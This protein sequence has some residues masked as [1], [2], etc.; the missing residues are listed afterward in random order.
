MTANT[1]GA[2]NTAAGVNALLANTTG[3]QN[4]AVGVN[5]IFNNKTGSNNIALGF[6]AGFNLTTG[7]N[8]VDIANVGAGAES[9]TIRIGTQGKQTAAFIAGV[10][11]TLVTGNAVVVSS[12]GKLGVVMS[13]ARFK[14]DIKDMGNSSEALMK[15]RPV[16]FKYKN[17]PEGIKQ[18]GLI[19]EEVARI[20]PELVGYGADGKVESVRYLTLTAMLLNELQ[21]Q[22]A[23]NKLQTEQIT[24]LS[25]K[26]SQV[27][28]SAQH[29]LRAQRAA[30]EERLSALEQ[31]TQAQN[32]NRNLAAAFD[33]REP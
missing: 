11:S 33:T 3:A 26:L 7:S 20:Y 12:S 9:N 17:D 23:Q 29:E 32:R 1:T 18:Y 19:A 10:S 21:K 14:R 22:T 8:N 2:L 25:A 16:T 31:T 5:G 4:T 6:D 13:S 30:F 28:A 27:E 15:L 24:T